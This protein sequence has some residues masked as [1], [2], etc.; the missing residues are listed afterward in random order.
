MRRATFAFVLLLLAGSWTALVS[1]PA[2]GAA[3]GRVITTNGDVLH[4]WD[5]PT[6]PTRALGTLAQG[7]SVT[8]SSCTAGVA[9][10]GRAVGLRCAPTGGEQQE[11]YQ[12]AEPTSRPAVGVPGAKRRRGGHHGRPQ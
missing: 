8:F 3:T 5:S 10:S 9:V 12:R 1:A 2:A 6:N 4:V 11:R 7:S